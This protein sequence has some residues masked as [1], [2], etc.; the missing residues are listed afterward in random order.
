MTDSGTGRSQQKPWT[1]RFSRKPNRYAIGDVH[2]CYR[3]LRVLVEDVIRPE[4]TDAIFLLGDY[5]DRGPDSKG[6]L[7]YLI[8]LFDREDIFVSPLLGNHE[9]LCLQAAAGDKVA[10]KIWYG[11]GGLATLKSF[12]VERP[13]DIPKKYL[14]FMAAMRRIQVKDDYVLVHAG[15]DFATDDPIHDTTPEFMLWDRS[16]RVHPQNIGDRTLVCGHTVT[17]LFEIQKSLATSV[18]RLDNGCYDKGHMGYGS[19]VALNLNTRE[20][21]VQENCE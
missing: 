5:I 10:E 17:P 4:P 1:G 13:E 8:E 9:E 16:E 15:L 11:N 20:L 2:C 19:L 6:V 14:D 21:L 18:I 12:G 7:D 3:T